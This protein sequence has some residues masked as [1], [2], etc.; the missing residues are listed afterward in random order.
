MSKNISGGS[1]VG[2]SAMSSST[3]VQTER[4]A[5]EAW[6]MLIKKKPRAAML[7]HHVT[8]S[9]SAKRHWLSCLV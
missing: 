6:A 9:L 4:S 3:W 8:L 5:H 2:R 7:M 1:E